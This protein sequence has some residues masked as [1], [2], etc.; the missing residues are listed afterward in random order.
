MPDPPASGSAVTARRGFG[1]FRAFLLGLLLGVMIAGGAA[2][3]WVHRGGN[4]TISPEILLDN[5]RVR[6]VRWVLEPNQSTTVMIDTMDHI[7]VIVRGGTIRDEDA[8]GISKDFSPRTGD[9]IF[10][11]ATNRNHSLV[12]VGKTAF[13]VVTIELK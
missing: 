9:A 11:A 2:V 6:I 4:Q 12:N 7:S 3:M 10:E 8:N 1:V 13:E 5:Q